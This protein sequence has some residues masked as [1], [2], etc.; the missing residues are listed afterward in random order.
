MTAVVEDGERGYQEPGTHSLV[1]RK[2]LW[3]GLE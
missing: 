2:R 3:N 1:I